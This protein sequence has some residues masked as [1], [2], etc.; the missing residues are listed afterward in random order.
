MARVRT[1]SL[2][3]SRGNQPEPER[4]DG[5][6]ALDGAKDWLFGGISL[7]GDQRHLAGDPPNAF[8]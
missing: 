6:H 7:I 1:I 2:H 3:S 8:E 4:S 5:P